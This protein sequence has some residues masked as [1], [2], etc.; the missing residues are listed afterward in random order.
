LITTELCEGSIRISNP[1]PDLQA[2]DL[3]HMFE[4]FWQKN[5]A[6]NDYQHSGLGLSIVQTCA[7]LIP[8]EVETSLEQGILTISI[9]EATRQKQ[10]PQHHST[11]SQH[12]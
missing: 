3:D 1:A 7:R 5:S 10:L 6:H 12:S 2:A 8:A 9:R 4:R 11:V